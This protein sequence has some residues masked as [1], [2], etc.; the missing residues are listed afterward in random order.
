MSPIVEEE[1]VPSKNGGV[2]DRPADQ[3]IS[4]ESKGLSI[5]VSIYVA[6]VVLDDAM[7]CNVSDYRS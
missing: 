2:V 7:I 3:R 6:S 4:P 5:W 1:H